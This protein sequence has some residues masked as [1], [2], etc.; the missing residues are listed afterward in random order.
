MKQMESESMDTPKKKEK[1]TTLQ[2]LSFEE[3]EESSGSDNDTATVSQLWSKER[4]TSEGTDIEEL[5][6]AASK[7]HCQVTQHPAASDRHCQV[8]WGLA[9]GDGRCQVAQGDGQGL[10]EE[11]EESTES[12]GEDGG[13]VHENTQDMACKNGMH[14]GHS[15]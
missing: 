11:E 7:V 14:R 1:L 13:N 12:E 4:S 8:I 3:S 2:E 9:T 5:A 10:R 15:F 6:P